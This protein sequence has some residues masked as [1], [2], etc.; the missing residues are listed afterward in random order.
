MSLQNRKG[1]LIDPG[2]CRCC[3][4]IKKCRLLNVEYHYFGEIEVY[5]DMF[6]DCFGLV[7][8]R[9]YQVAS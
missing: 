4:L 8:S 1:P 6:I 5:V 2:L 7:V 9:Y 3:G